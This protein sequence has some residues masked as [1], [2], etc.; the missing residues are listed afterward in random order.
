MVDSASKCN[1]SAHAA[2]CNVSAKNT[3]LRK[4]YQYQDMTIPY[5][6]F[7]SLLNAKDGLKAGVTFEKLDAIAGECSDNEV[8]QY[9]NEA[10]AK[11]FLIIKMLKQNH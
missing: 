8:T 10:R 7:R 11:L 5:E 6:K 2:S 3:V 1:P 9:L 4:R